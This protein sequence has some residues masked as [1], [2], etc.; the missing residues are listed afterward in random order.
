MKFQ[1]REHIQRAYKYTQE[2][3]ELLGIDCLHY[4]V[5]SGNRVY[6]FLYTHFIPLWILNFSPLTN[7]WT[8]DS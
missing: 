7:Q 1:N 2:I 5:N 3:L 4:I 6:L 8:D